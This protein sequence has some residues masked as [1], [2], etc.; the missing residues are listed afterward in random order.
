MPTDPRD[1]R[2]RQVT[3]CLKAAEEAFARA[4]AAPDDHAR[5]H[6]IEEAEAWLL[7]AER[8]LARLTDRP[9]SLTRPNVVA[10]ESRSFNQPGTDEPGMVWRRNL[11]S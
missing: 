8:R 11:Q 10:S 1:P 9:I 3:H 6:L 7:K 2:Y 4:A 5:A